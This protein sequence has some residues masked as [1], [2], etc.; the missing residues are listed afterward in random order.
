VMNNQVSHTATSL[1]D[2][3]GRALRLA[4]RRLE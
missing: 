3:S 2:T 4:Q 1:S